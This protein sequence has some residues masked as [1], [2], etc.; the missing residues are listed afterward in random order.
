MTK[1]FEHDEITNLFKKLNLRYIDVQDR[2]SSSGNI[3]ILNGDNEF[4][5][6]YLDGCIE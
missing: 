2:L 4:I 5:V 1:Y 3:V 6:P